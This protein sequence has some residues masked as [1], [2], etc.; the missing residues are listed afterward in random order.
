MIK[1]ISGALSLAL[2]FL[3]LRLALPKEVGDLLTEIITKIL[4]LVSNMID[5]ASS[6]AS[7]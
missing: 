1:A 4:L 3:V 6:V 5:H 2:I 7:L